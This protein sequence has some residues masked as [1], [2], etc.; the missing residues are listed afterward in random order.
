MDSMP[1]EWHSEP[2]E[3]IDDWEVITTDRCGV[4]HHVYISE[5]EEDKDR[6]TFIV[7][8]DDS[9]RDLLDAR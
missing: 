4:K 2:H 8:K 6:A 5:R 3:E 7:A 9:V 1:P